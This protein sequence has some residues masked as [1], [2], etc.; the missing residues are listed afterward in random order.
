MSGI[1]IHIPF[2]KQACSYC[3]FYFVTKPDNKNAFS[4]KLVEEIHSK[5]DSIYSSN[6]IDTIYFGGGTPSLLR[7]EQFDKIFTALDRSFNLNLKEVTVELN[8]DDVTKEYLSD[9]KNIGV[10]RV[11]MGVQTFDEDLLKFMNRTHN[12][13]EALKCLELLK[14][15]EINVFTADLIYGNPGQTLEILERD[16]DILLQFDP[17]H[18]SAYS[19]TI[20]PKTRLGKQLEL[21]RLIPAEDETV[22]K[23]FELVEEKLKQSGIHRY[24]VSNFARKGAEAVHNANYWEHKNYLG[25]GPGAH[26]FRW[27]ESGTFAYRWENEPDLKKYLRKTDFS[28]YEKEELSLQSLAE[29]RIMLGLRTVKGVSI[30]KLEKK[31]EY[32]LSERQLAYLA[33][34]EKEGKFHFS[35]D[36]I[37]LSSSG[38]KIADALTLDLITA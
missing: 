22:E 12:S 4:D 13:A 33:R 17:P 32:K 25:L 9:L 2:C 10:N 36:S 1:Y 8:P 5:K 31:Y 38:L 18:V 24:E 35:T 27:D 21:G 11:S 26:S 28:E 6:V 7:A 20:E 19:L 34:K 37:R 29:E 3:D 15:S 30:E 14:N 23:H 16:L